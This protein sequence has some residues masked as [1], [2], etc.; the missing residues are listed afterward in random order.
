MTQLGRDPLGLPPA[1]TRPRRASSAVQ[2]EG[3]VRRTSSLMM[4]SGQEGVPPPSVFH[5]I[6]APSSS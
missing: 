5:S 3:R 4:R 1:H 2:S 6:Q